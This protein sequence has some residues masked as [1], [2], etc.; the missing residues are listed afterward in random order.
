MLAAQLFD[1]YVR[2]QRWIAQQHAAEFASLLVE[3]LSAVGST[4]PGQS[5]T[6]RGSLQ[7]LLEML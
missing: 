2:R 6:V 4:A 5:S 1:S 3:A 7:Q